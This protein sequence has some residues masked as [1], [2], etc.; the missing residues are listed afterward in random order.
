[1]S[2]HSSLS[3]L[4]LILSAWYIATAN[5]SLQPGTF[6]TYND[7]DYWNYSDVHDYIKVIKY[8]YGK[9]VD[10]ACREMRLRSMSRAMGIKLVK[11]HMVEK[12]RNIKLYLDW[13][14]ITENALH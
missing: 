2:T 5:R 7:V 6:D 1:M 4:G 3:G 13:L 14:G 12:P 9:V 10:Y 8:G 11:K